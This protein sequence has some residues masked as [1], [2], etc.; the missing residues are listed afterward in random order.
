LG[1][2]F[3]EIGDSFLSDGRLLLA[4]GTLHETLTSRRLE[5]ARR[6][7]LV[8]NTKSSLETA[9]R[10]FRAAIVAAPNL[11]E[12]RLRLAHVLILQERPADALRLLDAVLR[13]G[14]TPATRYLA[15]MFMGRVHATANRVAE[16]ERSFAAGHDEYPCGQSGLIALSDVALLQGQQAKARN[17]LAVGLK[18][19]RRCEDPWTLYDFGQS[20]KLDGLIIGLRREVGD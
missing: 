5:A 7:A 2:F 10:F 14:T 11:A 9:G 19:S 1:L 12:A 6:A 20:E 13:D 18:D 4:E 15:Y 17:T 16:A 3:Q 8:P